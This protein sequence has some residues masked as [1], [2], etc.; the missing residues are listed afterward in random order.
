MLVLSQIRLGKL[1]DKDD[2]HE[3]H[4]VFENGTILGNVSGIEDLSTE[5]AT[6]QRPVI[7][8]Q[9]PDEGPNNDPKIEANLLSRNLNYELE[10][11]CLGNKW[12]WWFRTYEGHCNW[13]KK[14]E[15]GEGSVGS[16]RPRDYQQ[17]TYADG[18]SKP[19]EGPNPRTVSN[20]FFKRKK[21]IYYDHTPLL[22][23][24]IEF[25]MHDVTYGQDS[26][27]E[28]IEVSMPEDEEI[29]PLNTTI[30]VPR[31]G[32]MPR[33]GTSRSNP[34]ENIN[35]ATTW[36]DISSLYGSNA[37]VAHRLRSKVDGKL[38]TQE[39]QP[40]GNRASASNL[41]SST[42]GVPTNTRPGVKPE[43]LFAGGDPRTNEDWLLLG[44]HT[45]LFREHN[46]LCDILRQ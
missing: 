17:Y 5:I 34:R 31:T 25:I 4:N 26:T 11:E 40:P 37:D 28:F 46:R 16:A 20:A 3:L 32:A 15:S 18:I 21:K 24:L 27:D 33:T 42:V 7:G 8:P 44:I 29:F 41:P 45:V 10:P 30:R 19:R 39:A 6:P 12:T 36:L 38:L 22:L 43:E 35:M 2:N 9:I 14:G 23:G 1:V 13:L